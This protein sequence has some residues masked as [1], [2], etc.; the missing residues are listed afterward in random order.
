MTQ[1][2]NLQPYGIS[3]PEKVEW[4]WAGQHDISSGLRSKSLTQFLP[5]IDQIL[6]EKNITWQFHEL[7][8]KEYIE[9]L[10]Y[11]TQKMSELHYDIFAT[12]EWYQRK[13]S[14]GYAVEGIMMYKDGVLIGSGIV[15]KKN[16][17]TA[18]L[19]FKASDR[20]DLSSNSN[21]SLGAVIDLLFI[22]EVVNQGI[23]D[24]SSGTSRNAF[25][26]INSVGYLDYKLRFGFNPRPSSHAPIQTTVPLNES[27]E[28]IFYGIQ[29]NKESFFGF[30][31]KNSEKPLQ[32]RFQEFGLPFTEILY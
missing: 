30:R 23:T 14:D 28:V 1:E 25:G 17:E 10:P 29:D 9:W 15:T 19:N 4:W 16:N 18:I 26:V 13:K 3:R 6:Q 2:I 32:N 22:R 11:Y 8:E 12:P 20:I 27:G 5:K 7:S 21:S 24:I 31:S